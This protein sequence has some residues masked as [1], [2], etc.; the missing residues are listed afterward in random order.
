MTHTLEN[1]VKSFSRQ[2]VPASE[3]LATGII[4]AAY[5]DVCSILKH[6]GSL[7]LEIWLESVYST[8]LLIQRLRLQ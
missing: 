7:V 8:S 2:F 1:P 6:T 3:S 4:R 5:E